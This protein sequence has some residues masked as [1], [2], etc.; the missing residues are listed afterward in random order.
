MDVP[1]QFTGTPSMAPSFICL[2]SRVD[3]SPHS[4]C[5]ASLLRPEQTRMLTMRTIGFVDPE[6]RDALALWPHSSITWTC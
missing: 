6:L 1:K 4:R 5:D 3:F 2:E